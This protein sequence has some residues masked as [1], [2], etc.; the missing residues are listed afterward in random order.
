VSGATARTSAPTEVMGG[1]FPA[2]EV[3]DQ[4]LKLRWGGQRLPGRIQ[5]AAGERDRLPDRFA[6][7]VEPPLGSVGVQQVRQVL[8]SLPLAKVVPS[9]AVR[10]DA[11]GRL[12]LDVPGDGATDAHPVVRA[13]LTLGV[14]NLVVE[15]RSDPQGG[16]CRAQESL[17]WCADGRLLVTG[18]GQLLGARE[19]EGRHGVP[20][21]PGDLRQGG[22][23]AARWTGTASQ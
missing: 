11:P 2:E 23:H 1:G 4:R 9:Q 14:P 19:P 3:G 22:S 18:A 7:A 13:D 16:T 8:L 17:Q 10:V 15:D 21:P 20:E 6:V 5:C 12:D